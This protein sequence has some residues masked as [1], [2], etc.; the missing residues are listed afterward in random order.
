[1]GEFTFLAVV[2]PWSC[3]G[4]FSFHGVAWRFYYSFWFRGNVC[5]LFAQMHAVLR[6]FTA[7]C[8]FLYGFCVHIQ[9]LRTFMYGFCTGSA[10]F[11]YVYSLYFAQVVRLL[12]TYTAFVR[13]ER[14]FRTYTAYLHGVQCRQYCVIRFCGFLGFFCLCKRTWFMD[15][16]EDLILRVPLISLSALDSRYYWTVSTTRSCGFRSWWCTRELLIIQCTILPWRFLAGLDRA[17]YFPSGVILMCT[18]LLCG[19]YINVGTKGTLG[20]IM[21]S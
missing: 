4:G 16:L 20:V 9:L 3:L 10:Y 18:M 1:M 17:A 11:A 13:I 2:Q 7:F 5:R 12:R 8:T 6:M 19:I 14:L 15:S 21:I